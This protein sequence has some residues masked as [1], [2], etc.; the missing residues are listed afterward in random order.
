[1]LK[2]FLV[3]LFFITSASSSFATDVPAIEI[4]NS[5]V[6]ID[7]FM[8]EY[9]HDTDHSLTIESVQNKSFITVHNRYS[10]GTS[11]DYLWHRLRIKNTSDNTK[12]VFL[13]SETSYL[14]LGINFYEVNNKKVINTLLIDLT[15]GKEAA[16][17]MT[18]SL[19]IFPLT[20]KSGETTT[21]YINSF[22]DT[23]RFLS[24][25]LYDEKNSRK[26]HKNQILLSSILAGMMLALTFYHL[27]FFIVT[28]NKEYFYYVLYLLS[29]SLVILQISGMLAN[30]V[31][32]YYSLENEYWLLA[33]STLPLFL[34]LFIKTIFNT[35]DSPHYKYENMLLNFIVGVF[36]VMFIIGLMDMTVAISIM[37]YPYIVF[38][39]SIIIISLSMIIKKDS[40]AHYFLFGTIIFMG[41]NILNDLYVMSILPYSLFIINAP[42]IGI[43]VEAIALAIMLSHRL[44]SYQ[45]E[46]IISRLNAKE[47]ERIKQ[48]NMQLQEKI[49]SAV[50]KIR[51]KDKLLFEQNKLASM[52]QML[53]H[54]AHQW[55]QPLSQ[56]NSSVLL[57]DSY[58]D[59]K[60]MSSETLSGSLDE[61][62]NQTQYLSNT[63][64]SFRDYYRNNDDD[65]LLTLKDTIENALVILHASFTLKHVEIISHIECCALYKGNDD[66]IKQVLIA[67][68]NNAIDVF[69]K[70]EVI[71]PSISIKAHETG[72]Q[73]IIELCDTGGGIDEK[74]KDLIFDKY[75]STKEMNNKGGLG[76]YMA[77]S[78]LEEDELGS[79]SVTNTHLGACFK[80]TLNQ[81]KFTRQAVAQKEFTFIGEDK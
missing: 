5:E 30:A 64:D 42:G 55:R 20:I 41:C 32:F 81:H 21:V 29:S 35:N 46:S 56:I 15:K 25:T 16:E 74:N 9:L 70:N 37:P 60:E 31:G 39:I 80:M 10:P 79:L 53:E 44:K 4:N 14:E 69:N 57:M 62:E 76:L 67:I 12:Q 13:H 17:K 7:D 51:K 77:K 1:M 61:I 22:N 73:I 54:I 75:F 26:T 50:G 47:Q 34:A 18:G 58:L 72:E 66:K 43:T 71:N 63:I 65:E 28:K 27:V 36:T 3:L 8:M 59:K 6:R 48:Q 52:G 11:K 40:L 23:M 24:F 68:L 78:L 45:E 2:T 49:T 38:F 33:L 19:A